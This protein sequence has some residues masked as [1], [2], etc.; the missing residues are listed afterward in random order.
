MVAAGRRFGKT[1]LGCSILFTEALKNPNGIYWLV[2]PTYGQAKELAWTILEKMIPADLV[3]KKHETELS[4][5]L[6]NGSEIHLKGADNPET[7][8]GRGLR[9]IVIDEVA[10]IRNHKSVWEEVLRPSLADYQGFCIFIGTPKGKNYFWELYIKGQKKEDGFES[11]RFK[12]EDNPYIPRSEIKAAKDLTNERYFKQEYEASFEDYAGLIYPEFD[13][14][15]MVI[16]PFQIPSNYKTIGAIDPAVT[17]TF[18]ALYC[19]I[20]GDGMLF[21][22]GEYY[23]ANKR[24]DSVCEAIRGRCERWIMDPAGKIMRSNASGS[25]YNFFDEFRDQNIHPHPAHN[26]VMA[27]INHTAQFLK[28]GKIKIFSGC[29]N[30]I[31]ELEKYHWSE[32]RETT[33]G[34]MEPR[35]YKAFDHLCDCLR[36]LVMSRIEK[37][38][39]LEKIVPNTADW[40]E[41]QAKEQEL[42]REDLERIHAND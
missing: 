9:G 7:L 21:I 24:V 39:S 22:T 31:N 11:W 35:P 29:K 19:A 6:T 27:G 42:F 23:E 17:G 18:A 8:R 12:T 32:E 10:T 16:E 3:A 25:L 2:A 38:E 1:V 5:K 15:T 28:T 34:V 4:M 26:A 41:K 36:Y 30:L 40:W 33:A 37:S 20:D 14:K 13:Q